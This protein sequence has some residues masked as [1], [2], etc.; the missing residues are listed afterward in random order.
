MKSKASKDPPQINERMKDKEEV[1]NPSK[2][3]PQMTYIYTIYR[4][5]FSTST[6]K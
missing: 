2:S 3:K 4:D 1:S 6:K 5:S